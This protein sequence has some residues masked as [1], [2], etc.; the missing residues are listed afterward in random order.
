M[1]DSVIDNLI[2]NAVRDHRKGNIKPAALICRNIL[3]LDPNHAEALNLLGTIMADAGNFDQAVNLLKDAL[4]VGGP[5]SGVL[6][7]YGIALAGANRLNEAARAF[8]NATEA[9]PQQADYWFNLGKTYQ[10]LGRLTDALTALSKA[11]AL[12]PEDASY[13][14]NLGNIFLQLDRPAEAVI[15]FKNLI[16]QSPENI[17]AQ[18]GLGIALR[19]VG[20]TEASEKLFRKLI[21]AHPDDV[22]TLNNYGLTLIT[23]NKFKDAE[24]VFLRALNLAPDYHDAHANLAELYALEGKFDAAALCLEKALMS[25]PQNQNLLIKLGLMRQRGGYLESAQTVLGPMTGLGLL[26]ADVACA[27]VLRDLGCFEE[28]RSLLSLNT[29]NNLKEVA[30]LTSLGLIHLHEGDTTSATTFLREAL[31]LKPKSPELHLN[32]A[33]ALL[34]SGNMAEGWNAFEG[35]LQDKKY[36][37][38]MENLPGNQWTGEKLANKSILITNE[39]G[40]GDCFQ[41]VRYVRQLSD[42]AEKVWL[43]V[44]PRL[45]RLMHDSLKGC[46]VCDSYNIPEDVDY[47][48][49]LLSLPHVMAESLLPVDDAYLCADISRAETWANRLDQNVP[50]IGL[51]WQGNPAYETDYLRSIPPEYIA[52]FSQKSDYSLVSLQKNSHELLG[53]SLPNLLDFTL[54]MDIED[55]FFDT[56]AL[57]MSLDLIITSDTAIAHLAGALGRPVWVLL[58]SAPDWRWQLN[59]LDCPWYPTMKLF[60]QPAP[61]DWASVFA[62][63]DKELNNIF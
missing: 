1:S 33:H 53:K 62:S 55:G 54:E 3:K 44:S 13:R 16:S 36:I 48:L 51:A 35:R 4:V 63:V 25:N 37:E 9:A 45:R 31:K 12:E 7:N 43:S 18:N 59:R 2:A 14:L 29:Q 41:F 17:L 42:K 11:S 32:L 49:P 50:N 21:I 46:H 5:N 52:T 40:A 60:R 20:N 26:E 6:F 22:A 27:N 19:R 8:K 47:Y 30:R 61:R 56:A 38:S 23:R 39:Q 10:R 57:M 28:A 34:L 58:N 24:M 15:Q